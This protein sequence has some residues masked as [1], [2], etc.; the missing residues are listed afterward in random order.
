MLAFHNLRASAEVRMHETTVHLIE[1]QTDKLPM[2]QLQYTSISPAGHMSL[3]TSSISSLA[4][5]INRLL[6][7]S[8]MH[9]VY[10]PRNPHASNKSLSLNLHRVCRWSTV[11]F[12]TKINCVRILRFQ[13]SFVLAAALP[14]IHSLS[15][16]RSFNCIH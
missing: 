11:F 6:I 9:V 2:R 7:T 8:C 12:Q 15:F 14:I 10:G 5:T 3:C 13:L 1:R 4:K 16:R